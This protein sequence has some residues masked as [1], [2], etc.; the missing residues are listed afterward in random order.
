MKT[1]RAMWFMI[2]QLKF[3]IA[4]LVQHTKPMKG[5]TFEYTIPTGG[6][7]LLMYA[8]LAH[9]FTFLAVTSC[10]YRPCKV[11]ADGSYLFRLGSYPRCTSFK[12]VLFVQIYKNNQWYIIQSNWSHVIIPQHVHTPAHPN[13]FYTQKQN[14]QQN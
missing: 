6:T 8:S 7:D 14:E 1:L 2:S 4:I 5:E 10:D 13:Q 9:S 3:S 12:I 11:R